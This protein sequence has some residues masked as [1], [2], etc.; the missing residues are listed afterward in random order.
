MYRLS[1][2]ACIKNFV[3][4]SLVYLE[5]TMVRGQ[6]KLFTYKTPFN[7]SLSGIYKGKRLDYFLIISVQLLT[8]SRFLLF[9]PTHM[10]DFLPTP[11]QAII[12]RS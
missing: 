9:S 3:Y 7:A 4:F 1:Y 11:S 12:N 2:K 5:Y 6:G 8:L 10:R